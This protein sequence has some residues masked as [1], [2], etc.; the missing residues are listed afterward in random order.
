MEPTLDE[1]LALYKACEAWRDQNKPL[2]AE[3]IYQVDSVNLA[4]PELAETICDIIGYFSEGEPEER[5]RFED[6]NI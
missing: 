5:D 2:C 6:E 4:C 3:S 1:L